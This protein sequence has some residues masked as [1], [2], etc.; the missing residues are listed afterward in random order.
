ML[1]RR[2]AHGGRRVSVVPRVALPWA[3]YLHRGPLAHMLLSYPGGRLLPSSRL[4]RAAVV[5]AY[6]YASVY[7]VARNDYATIAFALG[8]VALT[9]RRYVVAGGPQR[10]ARL[11]ALVAA[12]A[13]GSLSCWGQDPPRRRRRRRAVLWI[14]DLIVCPRGR[15]FRGS[16]LGTMGAGDGDG[17]GGRP[18]RADGRHA[19]RPAG[20]DARR[21]DTLVGYRLP[22][23]DRYVDETGRP[24]ELPTRRCGA[25]HDADPR[26]RPGSRRPGPRRGAARRSRAHVGRRGSDAAR[27]FERAPPGGGARAG[28]GRRGVEA[29][30]RCGRGRAA[31]TA[32]GG[33]SGRHEPAARPGR[34]AR[35]SDRS[36][37]RA[38]G[39]GGAR[40]ARRAGARH[41][42]RRPH[43]A[44]ARRG[45]A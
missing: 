5:A 26:R 1:G 16:A 13:S 43:R 17:T 22:G 41:P 11:A 25:C 44:R 12:T 23:Q 7:P 29:P 34:R 18:G 15:A 42:P 3:V 28:R 6:A 45:A 37:A 9:S 19:A 20:P 21:S 2:A 38:P 33:A 24:V 39:R 36:R 35:G 31:P 27:G 14:Y 40:R 10:R 32:R 30:D 4:D 8:L